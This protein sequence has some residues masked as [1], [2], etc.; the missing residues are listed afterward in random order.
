MI[1]IMQGNQSWKKITMARIEPGT[2]PMWTGA[3]TTRN[4]IFA[5]LW[6]VITWGRAIEQK[7]I[8]DSESAQ[9]ITHV[10]QVLCKNSTLTSRLTFVSLGFGCRRNRT[11]P[12]D[13]FAGAL[14][15]VH[16]KNLLKHFWMINF[17]NRIIS[18]EK[19][20]NHSKI[21]L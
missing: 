2:S 14:T 7:W 13:R 8:T 19:V 18:V 3:L 16:T 11:I 17:K 21:K 10:Y 5:P 1:Y 4:A 9:K 15:W 12:S 6:R 20:I